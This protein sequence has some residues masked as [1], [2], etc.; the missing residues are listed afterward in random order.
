MVPDGHDNHI[1]V[2]YSILRYFALS[3][4]KVQ[5][6][7]E[8]K[9]LGKNVFINTRGKANLSRKFTEDFVQQVVAHINEFPREE[10]HYS[11]EKSK[12][13]FLSA[14]INRL[15]ICISEVISGFPC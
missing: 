13:E 1:Q 14:N 12:K 8:G 7:V 6:L 4:H 10:N 9:K 5:G 11:R 3:H 2:S 15:F